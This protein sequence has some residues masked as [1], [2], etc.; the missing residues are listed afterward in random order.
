MI[1][2]ILYVHYHEPNSVYVIV[3]HK[4]AHHSKTFAR[5]IPLKCSNLKNK[6]I[7]SP[8]CKLVI[9]V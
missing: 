7:N 4:K 8:I 9:M 6:A 2:I 3:K 1:L 5:A